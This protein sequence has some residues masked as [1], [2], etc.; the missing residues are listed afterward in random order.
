MVPGMLQFIS[1]YPEL[2]TFSSIGPMEKEFKKLQRKF[3]FSYM[4]NS[5]T[6]NYM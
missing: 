5:I 6:L 1:K 2:I 4:Y 3:F